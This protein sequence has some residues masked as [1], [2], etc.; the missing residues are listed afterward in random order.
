MRI[1]SNF[2]YMELHLQNIHHGS[3]LNI[4]YNCNKQSSSFLC[5]ERYKSLTLS[6]EK[7]STFYIMVTSIQSQTRL[8]IPRIAIS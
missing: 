1:M 6:L 8:K 5:I 3:R 2:V 7:I 4:W